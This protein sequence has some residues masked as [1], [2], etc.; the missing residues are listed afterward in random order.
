[1]LVR[2]DE[3][4]RLF[5]EK[6]IKI[7]HRVARCVEA[8]RAAQLDGPPRHGNVEK[9]RIRAA[10]FPNPLPRLC[11]FHQLPYIRKQHIVE[12]S[13]F[14]RDLLQ[15][16]RLHIQV[17]GVLFVVAF[18]LQFHRAPLAPP[19][20]DP[21]QNRAHGKADAEH[22]HPDVVVDEDEADGAE[23]ADDRHEKR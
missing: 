8:N 4:G 11:K 10:A 21:G 1:M 23:A 22:H 18:V 19:H 9:V 13:L 5:E 3:G 6:R 14:V 7:Q 16:V 20:E 2:L 12:C 17:L 15:L